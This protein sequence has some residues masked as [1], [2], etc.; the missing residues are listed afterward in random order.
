MS[1]EDLV[2]GEL[3]ER[4]NVALTGNSIQVVMAQCRFTKTIE[5]FL[6]DDSTYYLSDG[7]YTRVYWSDATE[8][9]RLCLDGVSLDRPKTMWSDPGVLLLRREIESLII[10]RILEY[11]F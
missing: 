5:E 11:D 10:D 1:L 3:M 4:L 8:P 2:F 7:G 6:C 9:G